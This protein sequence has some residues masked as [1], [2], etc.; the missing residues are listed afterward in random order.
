MRL[1][2]TRA[3]GFGGFA[4]TFAVDGD[5]LTARERSELERLVAAAGVW[6]AP[7][8]LVA[9]TPAPDRFRYRL[10]IEDG[11]AAD[12]GGVRRREL[13]ADEEAMPEPLRALVRWV[14]RRGQRT[15]TA[16]KRRR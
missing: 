3:G 12:A 4:Q 8:E 1:T 13:R 16:K 7:A 5:R 10:S 2:L 9:R 11:E 15:P 6:S 14:E